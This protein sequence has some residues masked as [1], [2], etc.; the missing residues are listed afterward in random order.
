MY[1]VLLVL[2]TSLVKFIKSFHFEICGILDVVARS[3]SFSLAAWL[4]TLFITIT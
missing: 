3:C 2:V 1:K 4:P